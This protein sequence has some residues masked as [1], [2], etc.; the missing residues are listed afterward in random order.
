MAVESQD[1]THS[2]S[3][4]ATMDWLELRSHLVQVHGEEAGVIDDLRAFEDDTAR[5]RVSAENR[6]QA[7]HAAPVRT[8][9]R[10][11]GHH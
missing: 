3:W 2:E 1:H 10:S 5:R 4:A 6:H 8:F 11:D 7:L 9:T